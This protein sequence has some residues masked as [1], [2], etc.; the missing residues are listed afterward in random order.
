MPSK[1]KF[2][3]LIAAAVAVGAAYASKVK[4]VPVVG[5]LLT[6]LPGSDG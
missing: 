6:K 5:S 4:S 1:V 3:L 2:W